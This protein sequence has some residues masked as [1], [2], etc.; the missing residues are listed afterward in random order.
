MIFFTDRDLGSLF[1]KILS[2]AGIHV[3]KHDAHFP[4]NTPDDVWLP[5]VGGNGWFGRKFRFLY[6]QDR[7]FPE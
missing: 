6:P 1:P 5:E 3:E 2:D 7:T 4:D